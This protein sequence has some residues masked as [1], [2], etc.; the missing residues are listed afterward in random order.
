MIPEFL[1]VQI[2]VDV[3]S[4]N[5]GRAGTLPHG[6]AHPWPPLPEALR[7]EGWELTGGVFDPEHQ[8]YRLF[9]ERTTPAS[10]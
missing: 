2:M 3:W 8:R 9:L 4:D 10:L 5:R 1:D 6:L 7:A